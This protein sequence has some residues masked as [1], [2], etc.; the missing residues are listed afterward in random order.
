VGIG[1]ST[2]IG[3]PTSGWRRL[4]DGLARFNNRSYTRAAPGMLLQKSM[5]RLPRTSISR[6]GL[7]GQR[8]LR[9]E[10]RAKNFP[11]L[12]ASFSLGRF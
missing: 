10:S 7:T 3:A 8:I 6:M 2:M 12:N 1:I 4:D 11:R 9:H 5:P